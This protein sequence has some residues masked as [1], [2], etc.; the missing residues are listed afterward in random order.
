MLFSR[1]RQVF[2]HGRVQSCLWLSRGF[3]FAHQTRRT[4]RR[5]SNMGTTTTRRHGE[6]R[7]ATVM[8][9]RRVTG[10]AAAPRAPCRRVPPSAAAGVLMLPAC[11]CRCFQVPTSISRSCGRRS[12]AMCSSSCC[13]FVAG[14]TGQTAAQSQ[15]QP[16]QRRGTCRTVC[17]ADI[18][19]LSLRAS[20][21]L[22]RQLSA[23][24]RASRPTRPDKARRLGYK[25]KQV[26][27]NARTAS[28]DV[29]DS[30]ATVAWIGAQS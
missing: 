13:A 6:Q 24:H 11:A 21:R 28:E 22:S 14:S 8:L 17:D 15:P 30:G 1:A 25:A 20:P 5:R 4:D 27:H 26:R 16:P 9:R 18:L 29:L 7:A 23:V 12:R 19:S 10:A 3:F 2:A